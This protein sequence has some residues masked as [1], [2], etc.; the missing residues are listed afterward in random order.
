MG[1]QNQ[2]FL[3][4]NVFVDVKFVFLLSNITFFAYKSSRYHHEQ[5]LD[6]SFKTVVF[7][8]NFD[9]T[10]CSSCMFK[11]QTWG[12][13]WGGSRG[14][15]V[16]RAEDQQEQQQQEQQQEQQASVIHNPPTNMHRDNISRSGTPLTLIMFVRFRFVGT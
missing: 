13:S 2:D 8:L 1:Y 11:V 7:S 15:W 14:G 6:E 5:D 4:K 10:E 12:G 16:G 9:K 3:S